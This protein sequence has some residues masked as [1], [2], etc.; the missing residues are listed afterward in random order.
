VSGVATDDRKQRV[1]ATVVALAETLRLRV[2]AEGIE[3]PED[4]ERLVA[5]G[6][7][8]GQGYLFAR[9]MQAP[10]LFARAD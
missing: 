2:V 5:L 3:L 4:A 10:A 7:R 6:C 1:V 8:F 9:P